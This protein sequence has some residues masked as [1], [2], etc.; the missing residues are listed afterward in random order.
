MY[1]AAQNNSSSN[2]SSASVTNATSSIGP[3]DLDKKMQQLTNSNNSKDIATLAYIWGYPPVLAELTKDLTT[4]P[5][6]PPAP[7]RGP[8]NTINH[9]TVLVNASFTNVVRPPV[10][11]LLSYAR[12]DLKNGPLILQSPDVSDRYFSIQFLDAYS[13]VLSYIGTRAT[14]SKGGT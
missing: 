13:N 7:G 6:F 8:I 9:F 10:D 3:S 5:N 11:F 4:S 12:V 2:K 1:A 14:D